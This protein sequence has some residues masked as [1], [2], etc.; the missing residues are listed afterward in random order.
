MK[1]KVIKPD[2]SGVVTLF[3]AG[4]GILLL[5]GLGLPS[6]TIRLG[7]GGP[8]ISRDV[9]PVLYWACESVVILAGVL[10]LVLGVRLCRALIRQQ[11]DQQRTLEQKAIQ[12]FMREHEGDRE[13]KI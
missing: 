12:S 13:R 7:R 10:C 11:R 4:A 3:V 1:W 9:H 5:T 2:A 6:H 8:D